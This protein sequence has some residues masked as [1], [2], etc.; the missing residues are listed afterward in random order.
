MKPIIPSLREK[1]RYLV[2]KVRSNE[3]VSFNGAKSSL[4]NACLKFMGGLGMARAG[5]MIMNEFK[6]NKGIVKV[7]NKYL[8]ELHASLLLIEQIEGKK[9]S[10]ESVG[11]SG[12]LNKARKYFGMEMI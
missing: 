5:V 2:Y 10:V 4:E 1:N 8:N 11:V 3:K 9:A 7:N 12:L 6:N